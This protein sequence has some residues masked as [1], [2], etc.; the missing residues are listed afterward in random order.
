M[1][2]GRRVLVD[3]FFLR[4]VDAH[5][6]LDRFDDALGVADQVAVD[7]DNLKLLGHARQEPRKMRDL[8]V[9]AAHG[10][11]PMAVGKV[12]GETRID[13]ALVVALVRGDLRGDNAVRLADQPLRSRPRG[14]IELVG[15]AS[16]PVEG[17]FQV[18]VLLGQRPGGRKPASQHGSAAGPAR[19][20]AGR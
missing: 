10:G 7:L 3:V 15:D 11:E 8:P 12:A 6:R 16:E 5:Q 19:A 2:L 17:L 4:V 9:C 20:P 14:I 18:R 1:G 13:G